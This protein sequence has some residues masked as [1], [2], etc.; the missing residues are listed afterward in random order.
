MRARPDGILD[1]ILNDILDCLLDDILNN[2]LVET[3]YHM[4][5]DLPLT[6]NLSIGVAL[7]VPF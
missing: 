3:L 4:L 2:T 1:G 5:E 7:C 6:Y